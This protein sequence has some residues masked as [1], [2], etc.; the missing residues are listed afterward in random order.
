MNAGIQR[1]DSDC[2][3]RLLG[4]QGQFRR[5]F[6]ELGG[7]ADTAQAQTAH[8]GRSDSVRRHR[9]QKPLSN[10][11]EEV[12]VDETEQDAGL[13]TPPLQYV[14]LEFLRKLERNLCAAPRRPGHRDAGG[15]PQHRLVDRIAVRQHGKVI[16][17][18][19]VQTDF[20]AIEGRPHHLSRGYRVCKGVAHLDLSRL[21]GPP[22][23]RGVAG[24]RNDASEHLGLD[25][26]QGEFVVG[27][28]SEEVYASVGETHL[29]CDRLS[30]MQGRLEGRT[31]ADK[32]QRR[33]QLFRS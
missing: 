17:L 9:R 29:G 32:R 30:G 10:P 8:A 26:V 4:V 16:V 19:V 20:A 24:W 3:A 33:A 31:G 5:A 14:N 23:Q 21:G 7:L 28:P 15:G 6:E 12:P 11:P 25:E 13:I 27:E 1:A 18:R 2:F 22:T